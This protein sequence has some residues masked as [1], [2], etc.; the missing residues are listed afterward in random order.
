MGRGKSDCETS[1][2][3]RRGLAFT[4]REDTGQLSAEEGHDLTSMPWCCSEVNT[5]SPLGG[6]LERYR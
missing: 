2:D 5:E 4:R 3:H 6:L 1:Q